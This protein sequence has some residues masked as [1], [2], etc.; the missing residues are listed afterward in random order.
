MKCGN[1]WFGKCLSKNEML[2]E[3]V[4]LAMSADGLRQSEIARRENAPGKDVAAVRVTV[5]IEVTVDRGVDGGN[6]LKGLHVPE[7]CHRRRSAFGSVWSCG[8][9]TRPR[10]RDE[11]GMVRKLSLPKKLSAT[12]NSLRSGSCPPMSRA[13]VILPR[14]RAMARGLRVPGSRD[15]KFPVPGPKSP[16]FFPV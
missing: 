14:K 2:S 6:L 15:H 16:V 4:G 8:R 1:T 10:S 13:P 5:L 9:E 7:L 11:L 12:E 3:R